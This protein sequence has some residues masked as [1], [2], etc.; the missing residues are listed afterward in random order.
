MYKNGIKSRIDS[1]SSHLRILVR[2][3]KS[4]IKTHWNEG[5]ELCQ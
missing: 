4:I 3:H 5:I 2:A 1:K